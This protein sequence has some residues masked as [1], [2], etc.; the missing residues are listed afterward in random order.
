MAFVS[1]VDQIT[2]EGVQK[3]VRGVYVNDLG[4]TGGDIATYLTVVLSFQLQPQG[5]V[6][7][8]SAPV[9]NETFPLVNGGLV[10]VVNNANETGY[11][12]ARGY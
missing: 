7:L 6:L 4:S 3:V 10:T 5:A 8:A 2:T 12:E 1:Q 11:F 9:V